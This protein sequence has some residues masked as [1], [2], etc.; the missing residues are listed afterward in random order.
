MTL[1]SGGEFFPFHP[2]I[3]LPL[4]TE[5][6]RSL[7]ASRRPSR[8]PPSSPSLSFRGIDPREE[9]LTRSSQRLDHGARR[10]D[11]G[12]RRTGV[13]AEPLDRRAR[14][15]DQRESVQGQ[16]SSVCLLHRS[17]S[18]PKRR[19]GRGGLAPSFADSD[20]LSPFV[21][22]PLP[23][24]LMLSMEDTVSASEWTSP[25]TRELLPSQPSSRN[26]TSPSHLATSR[27]CA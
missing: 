8:L 22:P 11:L 6:R 19:R 14:P 2:V 27:R 20:S 17:C 9:K 16:C 3:P 5:C 1:Y 24:R 13:Q 15:I 21:S 23:S 4:A 12:T 26:L 18:P 10:V 7:E 25:S